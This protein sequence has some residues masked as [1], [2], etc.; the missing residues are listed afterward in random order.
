MNNTIPE[1]PVF[2]HKNTIWDAYFDPD[3]FIDSIGKIETSFNFGFEFV[4]HFFDNLLTVILSFSKIGWI[5]II[6]PFFLS[7]INNT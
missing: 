6:F 7:K 5:I 1:Y 3:L 4:I 2:E